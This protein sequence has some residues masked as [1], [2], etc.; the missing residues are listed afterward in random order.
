MPYVEDRGGHDFDGNDPWKGYP[1]AI[2]DRVRRILYEQT[3]MASSKLLPGTRI[4]DDIGLD[5]LDLWD[6]EC[7]IHKEFSIVPDDDAESIGTLGELVHYLKDR[8]G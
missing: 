7:E 4:I 2:V 6:F 8:T 3:G 5:S 1:V